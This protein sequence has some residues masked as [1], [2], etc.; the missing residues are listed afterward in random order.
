MNSLTPQTPVKAKSRLSKN[1]KL[2]FSKIA[3]KHQQQKTVYAIPPLLKKY[4]RFSPLLVI[5]GLH[6]LILYKTLQHQDPAQ[7]E[8]I[9]I[10]STYLPMLLLLTSTSFFTGSYIFLHTHRGLR[11]ACITFIFF[12]L[13]FQQVIIGPSLVVGLILLFTLL[14]GIPK[15][16]KLKLPSKK[17]VK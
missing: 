2:L 17:R 7:W 9:L 12:F 15:L 5:S 8:N 3:A 16:K 13:K 10:P 1:K 6:F 4:L 11:I 14:E